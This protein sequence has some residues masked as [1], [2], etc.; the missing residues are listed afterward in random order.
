MTNAKRAAYEFLE[1]VYDR[2]NRELPSPPEIHA[3]ID[4]IRAS[5]V[6]NP[7][8]KHLGGRE[9][10][11]TNAIAIPLLFDILSNYPGMTPVAAKEAFLSESYRNLGEFCSGSPARRLRHPFGKALSN[12]PEKIY[13]QWTG[14]LNGSPFVACHL[15]GRRRNGRIGTTTIR[16]FSHTMRV[17]TVICAVRGSI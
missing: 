17:V 9:H 13:A 11:F 5:A 8:Q 14:K 10:T 1:S 12:D 3:R 4:E 2:M 16:V 15:T 7:A 6:N